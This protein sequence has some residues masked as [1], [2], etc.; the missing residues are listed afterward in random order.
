MSSTFYRSLCFLM[1]VV[2]A[3][4]DTD[5]ATATSWRMDRSS[6]SRKREGGRPPPPPHL[7]VPEN[8]SIFARQRQP[9]NGDA[10]PITTF[11]MYTE[12]ELDHGW[13]ES[14]GGFE[15]LRMSTA[16]EKLAEV[17]LRRSLHNS[18]LRVYDPLAAT[19]FYVPVF[20]FASWMLAALRNCSS[21]VPPKLLHSHDSRMRMAAIVL[22]KSPHWQRCFG[23]DHVFA[24]SGTDA[25]RS[26]IKTRMRPLSDLLVCA[27]AG[28]YKVRAGGGCQVE[29]PYGAN[30]HGV[31]LYE[32]E[33]EADRP[34][35]VSFSGTLDVCCSGAR[36]RCAVGDAL[37]SSYDAPDVAILA[38]VRSA[39]NNPIGNKTCAARTL[40]KL[41]AVSNASYADQVRRIWTGSFSSSWSFSSSNS[42]PSI[43]AAQISMSGRA[44]HAMARSIFC[45]I[46]AGDT[47]ISSRLYSAIGAGCLPV[48]LGDPI[49][50]V[51]AFASR[52]N[53]SSFAVVVSEKLFVRQPHMLVPLLRGMPRA[54]VRRRQQALAEARP[55]I[56]FEAA[57]SM[58]AGAN[59]LE[60]AVNRCFSRMAKCG[61]THV[62]RHAQHNASTRN[63]STRSQAL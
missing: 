30:P 46:P 58:R 29:V 26:R 43:N 27:T 15:E 12:P 41:E 9:E 35:L 7:T 13:L 16:S 2:P 25:P 52:V 28:R 62:Q 19:V 18:P 57:N 34:L 59:F 42:S 1:V 56:V 14:C 8:V 47:Y 10:D 49:L 4:S 22:R 45:L 17:G 21:N 40:S 39:G 61:T 60:L 5:A 36:I 50:R 23:C 32:A 48:I 6:S 54:E 44:G 63:A 51:A 53:Y 38:S 37:V 3:K 33:P 55:H 31:R 24:S 11:Y 20:E